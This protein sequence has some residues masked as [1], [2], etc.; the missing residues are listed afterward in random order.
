MMKNVERE[1]RGVAW[2]GTSLDDLKAFPE[3]V[4]DEMGF[5]LH[6]VQHGK[7]PGIAKPLKGFSGAS[8]QEL[9]A[10]DDQRNTYRAVYTV[11]FSTAVYVLHAFQ[12][13]S[14]QG[15]ATPR[16]EIDMV[17]RRLK[18]AQ[19]E[20]KKRLKEARSNGEK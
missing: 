16:R 15:V 12:K 10:D 3:D 8:V 5:A 20:H 1:T 9:K 11:K 4:K 6:E 7:T 13:K 2:I 18:A 17:K 19:R 14:K